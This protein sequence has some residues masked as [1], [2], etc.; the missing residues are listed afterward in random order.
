MAKGA[1]AHEAT[2]GRY[3]GKKLS[4]MQVY[5][6]I[7]AVANLTVIGAAPDRIAKQVLAMRR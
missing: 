5:V 2:V 6:Q 3:P 4:A 7:K 1:E